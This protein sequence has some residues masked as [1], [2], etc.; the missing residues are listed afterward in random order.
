MDENTKEGSDNEEEFED[1]NGR[2][3][4]KSN[5]NLTESRFKSTLK[6]P[7]KDQKNQNGKKVQSPKSPKKVGN[8]RNNGGSAEY[9]E[10]AFLDTLLD[11]KKI[12]ENKVKRVEKRSNSS[13]SRRVDTGNS[14]D[15]DEEDEEEEEGEDE[16]DENGYRRGSLYSY[17]EDEEG[18]TQAK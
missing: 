5:Y 12:A 14:E 11:D 4:K 16:G 9:D 8:N 2:N 17:D 10:F 6:S 3:G 15:E 1:N 7:K 18:D 13:F